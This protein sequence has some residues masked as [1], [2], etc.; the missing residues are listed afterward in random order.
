M[1]IL[2]LFPGLLNVLHAQIRGVKIESEDVP[3]LRKPPDVSVPVHPFFSLAKL[4]VVS[5]VQGNED[6]ASFWAKWDTPLC[7]LVIL[8]ERDSGAQVVQVS[9]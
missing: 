2:Q 3:G 8:N 1:P 9:R 5:V 4:C 7:Q 6:V